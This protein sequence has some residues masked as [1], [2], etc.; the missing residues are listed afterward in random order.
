[1]TRMLNAIAPET[2][3][4]IRAEMSGKPT[5]KPIA[6]APKRKRVKCLCSQYKKYD[7]AKDRYIVQLARFIEQPKRVQLR[8]GMDM[9][10]VQ[11]LVGQINREYAVARDSTAEALELYFPK[12]MPALGVVEFV[13]FS[14][15]A[16]GTK[17]MDGDN[18]ETAFKPIRDGLARYARDG[19]AWR[20]HK[21][22]LGQADGWLEQRGSSWVYRQEKCP[23]NPRLFG[24]QIILHC[25]P[26]VE[27]P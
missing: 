14:S 10:A 8:K 21:G 16:G 17:Q 27:Q 9:A 12:G 3:A 18:L 4:L 19:R 24:I 13:R 23:G 20:Q 6:P 2:A 1:M 22:T 11:R 15:R 5:P 25:A 26:R 7:P